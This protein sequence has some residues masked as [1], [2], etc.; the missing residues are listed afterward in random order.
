MRRWPDY[1]CVF[2]LYQKCAA[3]SHPRPWLLC[4][5][6]CNL[7]AVSRSAWSKL[8]FLDIAAIPRDVSRCSACT[9]VQ[10][11]IGNCSVQTLRSA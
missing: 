10:D 5:S 8:A 7:I 3:Y 4:V 2:M 11:R 9:H 1:L 6:L